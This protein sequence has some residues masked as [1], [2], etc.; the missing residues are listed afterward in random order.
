MDVLYRLKEAPV[1]DVLEGL[2]D[3]PSYSAVRAKLGILEDKG[4]VTHRED[5]PRY[6]YR[7]IVDHSTAET[8][9]LKHVV[10]TFFG[11]SIEKAVTAL[12]SMDEEE[13]TDADI[14]RLSTLIKESAGR[15]EEK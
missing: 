11:G 7:P 3:P 10:T 14:E 6:V 9:A 8:T 15:R 12:V 1:S 5:G 13:L 2:A 4:Y